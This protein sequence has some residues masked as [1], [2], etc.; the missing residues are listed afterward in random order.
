MQQVQWIVVSESVGFITIDDIIRD[1]RDIGSV[2]G[3]G[4]EPLE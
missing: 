4:D 2:L 1:R 3:S